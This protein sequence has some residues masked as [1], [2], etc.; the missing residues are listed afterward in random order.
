[1]KNRDTIISYDLTSLQMRPPK[2][3]RYVNEFL[4]PDLKIEATISES[5]AVRWLKKLGFNLHRVQK[6]VYVD[7]HE[8]A[9]VVI[10]R[11]ELINHM[12]TDILP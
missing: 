9:D 11:Q 1:M 3:R 7:G 8:R 2:L 6:G 10:A 4:L 12:Y 5:T